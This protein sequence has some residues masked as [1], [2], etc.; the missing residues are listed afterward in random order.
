MFMLYYVKNK[1]WDERFLQRKKKIS[2]WVLDEVD[3]ILWI[4]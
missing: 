4:M 3:V 1:F 2:R